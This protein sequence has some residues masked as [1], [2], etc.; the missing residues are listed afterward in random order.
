[1]IEAKRLVFGLLLAVATGA[2]AHNHG[3]KSG[4]LTIEDAWARAS[5]GGQ[6]SGAAYLKIKNAGA[7]DKLLSASAPVAN[8][9]E[10]HTHL[11]DGTTMRMRKVEAIDVTG[12]GTTELKPGGLHV[13]LIGLKAPLKAGEKF[14]LTLKF[15]RGGEVKVEVEV[16]TGAPGAHKH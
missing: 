12:G 1:M 15:E 10:L 2:W 7:A 13:M 6:T 3:V 16:R 9:V 5:A 14:P 8:A 4:D 11:M